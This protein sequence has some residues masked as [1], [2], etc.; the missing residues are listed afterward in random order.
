MQMDVFSIPG[1][2][3]AHRLARLRP[4]GQREV[5]A[6]ERLRSW[7]HRL[8]ADTVAGTIYQAFTVRFARAVSEAAIGD[9]DQAARW[10]SKSKL[11][12]LD[13]TASPWRFHPRLLELWEEGDPDLIGGRSWDDIALESLAGALDDL[14]E[15]YGHDP[16]AWR[17]GRVHGMRFAHP[18]ADG[19]GRYARIFD[20]LLS[21]RRGVGGGQETVNASGFVPHNGDFT[22]SW[23]SSFRLLADVGDP[24]RSRWQHM[25]GQS[26]HPGSPHYDDLL[27]AWAAGETQP[28]AQPAVATLRLEPA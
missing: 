16:R 6:I 19:E 12:F 24:S 4:D 21:R 9:P 5:R 8:D 13:M 18:F 26:G 2:Q 23:G 7:D 22:G 15:R 20:R 14:E 11:G 25:T 17:W 28:V 27:D 3:T 10:R 1:E